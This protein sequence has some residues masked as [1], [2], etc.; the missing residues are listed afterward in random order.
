MDTAEFNRKEMRIILEILGQGQDLHHIFAWDGTDNINDSYTAV[1]VKV[2]KLA[3]YN[4]PENLME[5]K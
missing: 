2:F 3:G 4:I 5:R 1:F